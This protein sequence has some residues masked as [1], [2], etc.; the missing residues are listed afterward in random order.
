M[1]KSIEASDQQLRERVHLLQTQLNQLEHSNSSSLVEYQVMC[2]S[3]IKLSEIN[4]QLTE[5]FEEVQK[6]LANTNAELTRLR[7]FLGNK[8]EHRNLLIERI[9]NHQKTETELAERLIYC[10]AQLLQIESYYKKW[11]VTKISPFINQSANIVI[12]KSSSG[13][14]LMEIQLKRKKES[15]SLEFIDSVF[16][17]P[18]K[19]FRFVI[20]TFGERQKEFESEESDFIVDKIRDL[21][22]RFEGPP[23]A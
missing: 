7:E 19:P 23:Q 2:K 5:E 15:F 4:S 12:T 21:L 3:N 6:K 10:R 20:K 1:Q 11:Q 13:Q 17:H 18:T 9:E 14:Y 8:E 22:L 16:L